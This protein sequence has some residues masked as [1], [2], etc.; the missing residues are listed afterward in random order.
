MVPFPTR[1]RKGLLCFAVLLLSFFAFGQKPCDGFLLKGTLKN[2]DGEWLY[3]NHYDYKKFRLM[4]S[5]LVKKGTVS[6][7]LSFDEPT[8]LLLALRDK[9]AMSLVNCGNNSF[10]WD[11]T[12]QASFSMDDNGESKAFALFFQSRQLLDDRMIELSKQGRAFQDNTQ[13]VDSIWELKDKVQRQYPVFT[14]AFIREH[15]N[16]FTSLYLLRS[17]QTSYHVDTVKALYG[18]LHK[19]LKQYASAKSIQEFIDLEK[20]VLP[21][22]SLT[23]SRGM[24]SLSGFNYYVVDFWGS[25]CVPCIESIPS[26]K[27]LYKDYRSK[28]IQFVG[29]AYEHNQLTA[30][31]KAQEKHQLPWPQ[32]YVVATGD[33][34]TLVEEYY[35]SAFPT[36]LLLDKNYKILKRIATHE[37]LA[38]TLSEL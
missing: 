7:R 15:P 37:Q 24:D 29:L 2:A 36:Y 32:A 8:V 28:N 35:I 27:Q 21:L 33:N 25:W 12:K 11:V 22:N 10:T 18:L 30:Y 38:K 31:Q 13:A 34:K 1:T 19:S 5:V 14:K 23:Y 4:D 20:K 26:L 6:V 16:S 17:G 9:R 3:I